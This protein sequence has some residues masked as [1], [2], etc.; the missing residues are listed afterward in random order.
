MLSRFS[1]LNPAAEKIRV[2]YQGTS[3]IREGMPVCFD[4][5]STANIDGYDIVDGA[6]AT[7]DEGHQNE[8]KY[9][10]VEDPVSANL[11]WFAGV[12]AG[13]EYAGKA[14]PRW[15]EI[16]IP[17]GAVVPVRTDAS[18]TVGVTVLGIANGS[19][20]CASGGR[21][22]AVAMETV[23]RS[24]DN[25]IV[26]AKLDPSIFGLYQIGVGSGQQFN[27]L[28]GAV[29]NTL[30]NVFAAT[31]G[32]VCGLMTHTTASGDIAD[33]FNMWSSLNYLAVTGAVTGAGYIRAVLAQ[34]NL[35]GATM[36]NSALY[37]WAL[38]AQLHGTVTNTEMQRCAAACFE[39]GL[40]ENPD[41]GDADVIFLY[42]NGA[43]DVDSYVHMWGDGEKA[44]VI[45]KFSGCG[46]ESYSS[47]IKKGGTGGMWTNTG[48]WIQ[49]PIDVDG[50]TYYIPAGAALSEA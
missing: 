1:Y 33:S 41:T 34:C 20:L 39:Y 35:E 12:V 23:D 47:L 45:W 2:Y 21:A 46:G 11:Q 13:A 25:D 32:T 49:I 22:V 6:G 42:A 27:G 26:L 44:T 3:T 15:L 18:T 16:F 31:S 40:S 5:D 17:N 7:T 10:R 50:T 19:T 28:T 48:A 8:G 24:T 38:H 29:A 37:A 4:Y 9:I 14:G 43:E 30:R 36:N